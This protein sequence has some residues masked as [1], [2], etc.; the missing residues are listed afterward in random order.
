[1]ALGKLG[2]ELVELSLGTPQLLSD[3]ITLERG[4][5][6]GGNIRAPLRRVFRLVQRGI[7]RVH[8]AV[9]GGQLRRPL[10]HLSSLAG[11]LG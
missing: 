11:Y 8:H 5:L 1:M 2:H 7:G 3:C 9:L 4:G 6:E 10:G